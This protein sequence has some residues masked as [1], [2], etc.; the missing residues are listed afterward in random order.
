MKQVYKLQS[1][2]AKAVKSN[3]NRLRKHLNY[4]VPLPRSAPHS[5]S[6][7]APPMLLYSG[8]ASKAQWPISL[9]KETG[10]EVVGLKKAVV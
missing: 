4:L 7:A 5:V 2:I 6:T 10:P 9:E 1:R 8:M 3:K